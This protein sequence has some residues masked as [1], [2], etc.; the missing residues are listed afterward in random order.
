VILTPKNIYLSY[1]TIF[2]GKNQEIWD[3]F[4][5]SIKMGKKSTPKLMG[6]PENIVFNNI[7][8]LIL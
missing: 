1:Y 8:N 5:I 4:R 6:V 7:L 3:K 2:K